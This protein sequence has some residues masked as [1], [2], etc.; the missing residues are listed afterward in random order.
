MCKEWHLMPNGFAP[1]VGAGPHT[2]KCSIMLTQ[3]VWPVKQVWGV[4]QVQKATGVGGYFRWREEELKRTSLHMSDNWNLP[5]FPLRHGSLTLMYMAS[6]MVLV[7]FWASLPTM[8]ELSTLVWWPVIFAW[9]QMGKG[10]MRCSLSLSPKILEDSPMH[11][12]SHSNLS[13]LY[14]QITPLSV[15]WY[16]YH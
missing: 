2:Y 12:S 8:E 11:S 1:N 14:L 15:L 9:P 4:D 13:H 3:A 7:M 16:T 5:M 10:A 6:M